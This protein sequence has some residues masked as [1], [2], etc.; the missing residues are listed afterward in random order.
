M[1]GSCGAS[2]VGL[3]FIPGGWG[4]VDDEQDGRM[5]LCLPCGQTNEKYREK[6]HGHFGEVRMV[7]DSDSASSTDTS[8]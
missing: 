5:G 6:F 7:S 3:F 2:G 1:C 8:R 4:W